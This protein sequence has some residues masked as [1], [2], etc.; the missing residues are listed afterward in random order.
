MSE[1]VLLTNL[2]ATSLRI[3][4][5]NTIYHPLTSTPPS[6]SMD[7]DG[8]DTT[9]SRPSQHL[10]LLLSPSLPPIRM[11]LA[12]TIDV[13]AHCHTHSV[14]PTL[15]PHP[16]DFQCHRR[17]SQNLLWR[18]SPLNLSQVI[19]GCQRDVTE[20]SANLL[21]PD[22]WSRSTHHNVPSYLVSPQHCLQGID[23]H[24]HLVPYYVVTPRPLS[25]KTQPSSP[26]PPPLFVIVNNALNCPCHCHCH[27]PNSSSS[28]STS[29]IISHCHHHS[30][31]PHF[32][33]PQLHLSPRHL[34]S[35]PYDDHHL[36]F[37]TT[38]VTLSLTIT[39]SPP[40]YNH[41]SIIAVSCSSRPPLSLPCILPHLLP[42]TTYH[43]LTLY[44][45]G[46]PSPSTPSPCHPCTFY[47]HAFYHLALWGQ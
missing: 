33:P 21:T 30:Q 37:S 46:L 14:I 41:N 47:H 12:S 2:A 10:P 31:P 17:T 7:H 29:P 3:P 25:C 23:R 13:V 1:T 5:N 8:D 19:T 28:H 42:T 26:A 4:L 20:A 11:V 40:S 34:P 24:F 38:A 22:K 44:H 15:L 32:M 18:P 45:H 16:Q 9:S 6:S 35:H 36:V 39:T 27:A 43:Q